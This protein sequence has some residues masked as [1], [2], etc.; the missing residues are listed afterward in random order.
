MANLRALVCDDE[1]PLRDLMARRLEKLGLEVERAESGKDAVARIDAQRYDLLITDI[2]MPDVTGLELLQR[3]K[4][5]DPHAQVVVVTASATLDNAVGALNHGAFAYLTKPF[6]HLTVFDNVVA[7]A[8][9]FR[10]ALLD[11]LRMGEVQRRRGDLLEEEITGRIRQVKRAQ[12]YMVDLLGCLPI[13]V[14]VL[15]GSGRVDLINN[16]AQEALDPIL[17]AGPTALHDLL[18][19]IPSQEGHKRGEV[20]VGA[21]R[22]DLHLNELSLAEDGSQQVLVVREPESAGPAM[23]TIVQEMLV[24]LRSGLAWLGRRDRDEAAQKIL[25]GMASEI[26]SLA[27]FLDIHLPPEDQL[28][29]TATAAP[30]VELP[31]GQEGEAE[32]L[33]PAVLPRPPADAP[34]NGREAAHAPLPPR[35]G[36]PA[37]EPLPQ[38]T[39]SMMLRKGMT[40]VLEGRLRKKRGYTEPVSRPEDAERMQKKI[41]RWARSGSGDEGHSDEE[42]KPTD[43]P[44]VWPPPL[45]SSN[46]EP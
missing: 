11:N 18:E 19:R 40:M 34:G 5:L 35:T 15:N 12:Q 42:S 32:G 6:D 7:R 21:R 24:N 45:P 37:T 25:R 16:R 10:R 14:A 28:V 23:G 22:L 39:G 27:T 38:Q 43:S 29:N 33:A 17:A 46:G 41:D 9:E 20:E 1:A 36:R 31:R 8:I 13:G 30:P 2:Y 44:K 3:M 26:A 4:A